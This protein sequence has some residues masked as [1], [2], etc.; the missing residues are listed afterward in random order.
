M[1]YY[2]PGH[3]CCTVSNHTMRTHHEGENNAG[4]HGEEGSDLPTNNPVAWSSM[5]EPHKRRSGNPS[6]V[7]ATKRDEAA[8]LALNLTTT[9]SWSDAFVPPASTSQSMSKVGL[10]RAEYSRNDAT[11]DDPHLDPPPAYR[12]SQE[13]DIFSDSED[14]ESE[15]MHQ[16]LAQAPSTPT[17][18]EYG[19]EY[20]DNVDAPLLSESSEKSPSSWRPWT[21]VNSTAKLKNDGCV[22]LLI[23]LGVLTVFILGGVFG[24]FHVG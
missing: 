8:A 13:E 12:S 19:T 2:Y 21:R 17:R 16:T 1:F 9:G 24:Y 18:L 10:Q 6:K 23:A 11:T 14:S 4:A 3:N 7:N 15:D 22:R 5:K 20:R